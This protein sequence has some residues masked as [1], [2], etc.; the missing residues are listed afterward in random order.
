MWR[1]TNL[2]VVGNRFE[3]GGE[4]LLGVATIEF[5]NKIEA[6]Q[7]CLHENIDFG[8]EKYRERSGF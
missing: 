7:L 4:N 1:L 3:V 5:I 8:N 2:A 6:F